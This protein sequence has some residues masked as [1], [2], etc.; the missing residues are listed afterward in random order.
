MSVSVKRYS[1][2]IIAVL[3]SMFVAIPSL[4]ILLNS[5]K[6]QQ[7]AAD[8]S[9]SIPQ[10]WA[11]WDNYS[12][13]FREAHIIKAFGNTIL[14]TGVSV[15]GIIMACSLTAYVIQRRN[16]AFCRF[17]RSLL[18]IGM[19]LPISIITTYMLLKSLNMSGNYVGIIL[20]YIA[21]SFAFTTYLYIG[22]FTG[23]PREIDEAASMDGTE[24]LRLYIKVIFPL[25]KPINATV[26][27][28]SFMTIWNDFNLSL[29]FLNSPSRFTLSLTVFFFFGQHS[30]DWNLVFAD[31]MIISLPVIT[32]YLLMQ[33][34]IVSGMTAGAIKG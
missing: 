25:L 30:A 13:V 12:T 4:L 19:I 5:F 17:L 20:L 1:M 23:I 34:H 26:F 7:E 11:I 6:N 3:I 9:L 24:G 31:I 8:L 16:D 28:L 22:F 2:E 32:V 33:K 21:T 14:V 27:I 10:V 15:V 18:L 29:Y